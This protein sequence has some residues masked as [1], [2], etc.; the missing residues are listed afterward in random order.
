MRR[1]LRLLALNCGAEIVTVNIVGHASPNT[2]AFKTSA[3]IKAT[4]F[5]DGTWGLGVVEQSGD[6]PGCGKPVSPERRRE[7]HE[8]LDGVLG[9]NPEVGAY[10]QTF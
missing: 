6:R 9:G 1:V 4:G 2:F 3:P 8:A 5:Q 10:N 7:I